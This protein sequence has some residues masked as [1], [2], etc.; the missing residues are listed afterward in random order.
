[1]RFLML[2][3]CL[4]LAGCG[5]PSPDAQRWAYAV[6][7]TARNARP[8]NLPQQPMYTPQ[9][10]INCTTYGGNGLYSTNCN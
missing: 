2:F 3:G 4:M 7:M 9:R 8:L 6:G 1:M 10:P 5:E